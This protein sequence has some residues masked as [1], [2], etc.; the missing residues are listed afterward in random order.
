VGIDLHP[1]DIRD[2]A[3]SRWLRALVWA[4]R[5]D[6]L[7]L[8][9]RALAFAVEIGPPPVLRG[10]A[11]ESLAAVLATAPPGSLPCVV[12]SFTTYQ[13]PAAARERIASIASD[14]GAVGISVEWI[15]TPATTV[16][17]DGE[18]LAT[19]DPHGHW[20]EAEAS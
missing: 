6:R 1:I 11:L 13:L 14:A 7:R 9:E 18:R 16:E 8:L 3:A 15:E 2:P 20:I 19:S 4:D 12:H 5:T 10:D 17:V